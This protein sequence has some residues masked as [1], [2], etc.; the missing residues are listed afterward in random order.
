MTCREHLTALC[1]V[2]LSGFMTL[3]HHSLWRVL[4]IKAAAD[5]QRASLSHT[6]YTNIL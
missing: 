3:F 5:L 4:K 2:P 6:T 1:S